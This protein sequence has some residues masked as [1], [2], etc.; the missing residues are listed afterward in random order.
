MNS[1]PDY[2]V[3][4]AMRKVAMQLEEAFSSGK[5]ACVYA[6]QLAEILL[7]IAEEL[8]PPLPNQDP[9]NPNTER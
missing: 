3:A 5:L 4:G 7:S 8:D 9:T 2:R 1:D 6:D